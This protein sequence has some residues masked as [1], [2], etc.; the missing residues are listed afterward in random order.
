[1]ML[2]LSRGI[3]TTIE[4]IK[5]V[6]PVAV[7]VHVEATGLSRAASEELES[8]AV[9]D[10]HKNNLCLDLITGKI[11]RDH[12][13]MPWLIRNGTSV[14]D[15][16]EITDRRIALDVLGLNFYPQWSTQQ[17]YIDGKGRLAY[18]AHEQDG[19]GFGTMIRD[20]QKRYDCPV[21]ITETS[22]FGSDELRRK[23]LETSVSTVKELREDGVPVLGYTWF[24]M[25]TMVDWRYRFGR[26]PREQY[27]MELGMFRLIGEIDSSVNDDPSEELLIK[28]RQEHPG[29][30][31]GRWQ[32]T[33]LIET[34]RG[35]I[36]NPNDAVGNLPFGLEPD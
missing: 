9:E 35:Y 8:L 5:E 6:D 4:A 13:L 21:M 10:S 30:I 34:F 18:R 14:G 12:P 25:F 24:P 31:F 7:M 2:Q 32:G 36:Q 23:W 29:E 16:R 20:L 26:G 28:A 27:R 1:M 22:A 15:V 33:P 11:Q 17:L 19:A 3:L